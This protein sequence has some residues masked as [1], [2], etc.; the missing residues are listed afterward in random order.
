MNELDRFTLR[1]IKILEKHTDYVIVSGY[2]AILLG[3]T[4]ATEDIDI[5][6][7]EQD[8]EKINKLYKELKKH[9]YWCLNSSN[10]NEI[11][12]YLSEGL[13]VRFALKDQT[14]PNFELKFA[15]KMLSKESFNDALIV[16]TK[17]GKI[18]I[19]SLERQIA[20]KK[21]YLKSDKD[22]EDAKYIEDLF[23]VH[24]NQSRINDYKKLIQNE[25]AK[26]RKR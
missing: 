10:V 3:R 7:E 12:S 13:A 26:T 5:F 20:F 22:M 6:I 16:M 17:H 11:F 15:K 9:G 1:F 4:R 21:Y 23:K 24:L 19:S 18:K 8:K 14:T 2:V 25:M